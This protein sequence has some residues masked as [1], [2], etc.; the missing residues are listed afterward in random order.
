MNFGLIINGMTLA[1]IIKQYYPLIVNSIFL[2]YLFSHWNML[3]EG[4]KNI[5]NNNDVF[6]RGARSQIIRVYN[7]SGDNA[8]GNCS[9]FI[10]Y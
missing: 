4:V 9:L 2:Q 6:M 5:I 1:W 7:T 3:D 8:K 10:Y